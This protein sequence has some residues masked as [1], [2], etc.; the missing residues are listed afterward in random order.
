[1]SYQI[2]Q[3]QGDEILIGYVLV[4]TTSF[5]FGLFVALAVL[6]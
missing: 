5:F 3:N 2:Q 1:M 4:A 6:L